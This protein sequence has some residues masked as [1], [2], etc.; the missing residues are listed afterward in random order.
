MIDRIAHRGASLEAPEN[1]MQAFSTAYQKGATHIECDVRLTADK[2]PIIIHDDTLDRTTNGKGPVD[3]CRYQVIE[4]LDAGSWFSD[5]FSG[6]TVPKLSEL[7]SWQKKSGIILHLEIKPLNPNT[8]EADL[9][10]ILDQVYALADTQK[11][12][13]LSFQ[14]AVLKRLQKLNNHIPTVFAITRCQSHDIENA[15]AANCYQIN[16]SYDHVCPEQIKN[17]Q[18]QGLRVGI[19]TVNQDEQLKELLHFNVDAVFVDDMNLIN[20]PSLHLGR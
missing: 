17:I 13:L 3:K 6:V 10:I 20:K 12:H 8:L 11:I 7:L 2:V 16:S 19:Y 4:T 18:N 1:T 14:Y 9:D 15:I 5:S